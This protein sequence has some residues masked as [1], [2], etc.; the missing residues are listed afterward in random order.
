MT[1]Y[2]LFKEMMKHHL[3][4]DRAPFE[5]ASGEASSSEPELSRVEEIGE[6]NKDK[7]SFDFLLGRVNALDPK[8]D[9]FPQKLFEVGLEAL[10]VNEAFD[11]GNLASAVVSR[12]DLD[13]P[14]RLK[15]LAFL[16]SSFKARTLAGDV[17]ES[18]YLAEAFKLCLEEEDFAELLTGKV[19]E[20]EEL[21]RYVKKVS[22][23][24]LRVEALPIGEPRDWREDSE[25]ISESLSWLNYA[26]TYFPT[27]YLLH[28][29]GAFEV[30]G[31]VAATNSDLDLFQSLF[32]WEYDSAKEWEKLDV[33][34]PFFDFDRAKSDSLILYVAAADDPM[35]VLSWA[36]ENMVWGDVD[37]D[38][39]AEVLLSRD[40]FDEWRWLCHNS[41]YPDDYPAL[42]F[43]VRQDGKRVLE[44]VFGH[45]V[46]E[47]YQVCEAMVEGL[48]AG[49]WDNV[50]ELMNLS[51]IGPNHS[52]LLTVSAVKRYAR[53]VEYVAKAHQSV[54]AEAA[55]FLAS[56]LFCGPFDV[57]SDGRM[58][59]D[60]FP[61]TF[62]I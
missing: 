57:L 24:E 18:G 54:G 49:Q 48:K 16:G 45:R 17:Y 36:F 22:M 46:W 13:S 19:P 47:P 5:A 29:S 23:P 50:A 42:L 9:D 6:K 8:S 52:R 2:D 55:K 26:A 27:V 41:P 51:G 53:R 38:T 39:L 32:Q 1:S 7:T 59:K 4:V 34:D 10:P 28:E 62:R 20:V 30:L 37:F 61:K 35:P 25:K 44:E 56:I 43:A 14:S 33:P 12:K 58:L 31:R 40:M 21:Q 3:Q 60:A 11:A 15:L